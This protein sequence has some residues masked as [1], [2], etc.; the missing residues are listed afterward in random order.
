MVFFNY[1]Q[2]KDLITINKINKINIFYVYYMYIII[3]C[4]ILLCIIFN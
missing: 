3:Y 2:S 1:Y 4:N